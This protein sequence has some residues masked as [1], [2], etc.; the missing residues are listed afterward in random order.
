MTRP[1]TQTIAFDCPAYTV[2]TAPV[3]RQKWHE[4]SETY[5]PIIAHG[6]QLGAFMTTHRGEKSM[7]LFTAGSV[8][9]YALRYHNDPIAAHAL[10]SARGEKLQW[11]NNNSVMITKEDRPKDTYTLIEVGELVYMEG[12]FFTVALDGRDHLRLIA[13]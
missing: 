8:I 5:V 3:S 1:T 9:G 7:R 13:S 10:S 11:I 6:D 4:G 2:L 12:H